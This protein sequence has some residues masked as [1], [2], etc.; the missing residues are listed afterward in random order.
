MIGYSI[1]HEPK[2]GRERHQRQLERVC[3]STINF[4]RFFFLGGEMVEPIA[5]RTSERHA[6]TKYS[7]AQ[8]TCALT[9]SLGCSQA[10]NIILMTHN[11]CTYKAFYEIASEI[12]VVFLFLSNWATKQRGARGESRKSDRAKLPKAYC[13]YKSQKS[14]R[15]GGN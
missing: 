15:I 12:E 10:T 14:R 3:K 1:L 7:T 5:P 4:L 6:S 11:I 2:P 9:R 13:T 8:V